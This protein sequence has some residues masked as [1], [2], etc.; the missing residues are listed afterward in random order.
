MATMVRRGMVIFAA[1]AALALVP[2]ARRHD[3]RVDNFAA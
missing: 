3:P 1:P 2:T